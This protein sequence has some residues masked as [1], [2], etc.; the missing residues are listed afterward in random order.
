MR[1][2]NTKPENGG[3]EGKDVLEEPGMRIPKEALQNRIY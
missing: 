1:G 2:E 3:E